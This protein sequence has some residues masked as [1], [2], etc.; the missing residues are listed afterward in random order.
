MRS[1]DWSSDVCSSDLQRADDIVRRIRGMA[2]KQQPEQVALNLNEVVQESLLF[3]RH[4]VDSRSIRVTASYTRGL[5]PV[6]GDRV[7]LQQVIVNLLINAF[8]AVESQEVAN[9]KI[10][11]ATGI[12]EDNSVY[13]SLRDKIG[14][15]HV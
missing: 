8:Q 14:R 3:V 2:A 11:L 15:A 7:Q 9:R 4:E 1:S 13:F 6:T 12:E 10:L 5:E